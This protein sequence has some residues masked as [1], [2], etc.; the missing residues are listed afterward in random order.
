VLHVLLKIKGITIMS[1]IRYPSV[2]KPLTVAVLLGAGLMAGTTAWA[3]TSGTAANT[4]ILNQVTVNYADAGGTAQTALTSSVTVKVLLVPSV[5]NV[6]LTSSQALTIAQGGSATYNY[7]IQNTSNGQETFNL[8]TGQTVTS[9]LCTTA[10]SPPACTIATTATSSPGSVTLGA[11]TILAT[12]GA[13]VTVAGGSTSTVLTVPSDTVNSINGLVAGNTVYIGATQYS[14]SAVGVDP[15]TANGTTTI[16]V[17]PVSSAA[18]A[19]TVASGTLVQQY[20]T[21]TVTVASGTDT[22]ATTDQTDTVSLTATDPANTSITT[23]SSGT[24]GSFPNTVTTISA[25]AVTVTKYVRN[26]SVAVTGGGSSLSFGGNTYYTTGVTGTPGQLLEYLIVVANTGA[27]SSATKIK[28]SDTIENFITY[29][30]GTLKIDGSTPAVACG[31]AFATVND[32]DDT[33]Q[34]SA[35]TGSTGALTVTGSGTIIT[36]Y[37]GSNGAGPSSGPTLGTIQ[38]GKTC[39]MVYQVQIN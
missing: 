23:T 14:I 22:V 2:A 39:H 24:T 33:D 38:A 18:S 8:T 28:V 29:Q 1:K 4:G 36:F 20:T 35:V 9:G 5:P 17:V 30:A 11:T 19:Q 16:T 25:V 27:T 37:P 34:G 31:G 13:T 10:G 32:A 21:F 26:A 15:H 7:L 6:T 12:T 3:A